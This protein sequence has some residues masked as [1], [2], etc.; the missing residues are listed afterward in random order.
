M[1][2]VRYVPSGGPLTLRRKVLAPV[3][4]NRR[5][6]SST[7]P[8]SGRCPRDSIANS[9]E[10]VIY[11]T[12]SRR[13]LDPWTSLSSRSPGQPPSACS[14]WRCWRSFRRCLSCRPV[15]DVTTTPAPTRPIPSRCTT[16]RSAADAAHDPAPG[17]P[18]VVR[19]RRRT[20]Q[21]SGQLGVASLRADH[22][23]G[24]F[25]GGAHPGR[26][27]RQNGWPAGSAYTC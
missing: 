9:K 16:T 24:G 27:I 15:I 21:G 10:S 7:N 14:S 11:F 2:L 1:A 23:P 22:A 20:T 8:E 18:R 3:S 6:S 25:T 4:R 26:G 17:S 5:C 13:T 19:R 12:D